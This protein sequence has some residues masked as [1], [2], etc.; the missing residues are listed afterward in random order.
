MPLFASASPPPSPHLPSLLLS[1]KVFTVRSYCLSGEWGEGGEGR[2][3]LG[4]LFVT[5]SVWWI[6]V[7]SMCSSTAIL[8]KYIGGS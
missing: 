2:R 8:V 7:S 1:H 6:V 5:Y 3:G 4:G